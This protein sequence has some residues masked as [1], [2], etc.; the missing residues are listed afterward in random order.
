MDFSLCEDEGCA[1]AG[2]LSGLG[3]GL[4]HVAGSDALHGDIRV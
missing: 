3:D 2:H 4:A 1:L